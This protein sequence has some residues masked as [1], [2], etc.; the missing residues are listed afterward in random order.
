M[1]DVVRDARH[2]LR[3]FWQNP[4]FTAAAVLALALGIG[5]NTA[6]F[7]IVNAVLLK[8][9]PFPEP[10][11]LVVFQTASPQGAFAG[12]SPAKFEHW[13]AQ[14]SVVTDV[15]AYRSN[16][17][18][19]TGEGLPEQLRAG[20]VSVDYFQP[21][22]RADDPRA[23]VFHAGGFA[24]RREGRDSQLR[25]V[26]AAIRWTRRR[27]RQAP[28]A[29]Q[30]A[31]HRHRHH[32]SRI[33]RVRVRAVAGS[34]DSVPVRSQHERPGAL[35]PDGRTSE[36]WSDH[37]SGAS[38]VEG[39]HGE[40]RARFKDVFGRESELHRRADAGRDGPRCSNDAPHPLRRGR[41]RPAHRVRQRR[42]PAA[43]PRHEPAARDRHPRRHRRES[44]ADHPA[45]AR[46]ERDALPGRRRSRHHPRDGR[47]Q[48][49]AGAEHRRSASGW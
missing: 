3:M 7:S 11:R 5:A 25:S 28:D 14:S 10:D 26:A 29:Q 45:A 36:T 35:F 33:R 8:P 41:L 22:R 23:D 42:Q 32:R 21:V 15:S 17:V 43:H 46:R 49:A 39:V 16:I 40:F 47:H 31:V 20:Q 4:G 18:N 19:Y 1:T 27:H 38:A 12:A 9:V 30:R 13:R 48:G 6:I 34:L 2:S 37:R 24:R 44:R